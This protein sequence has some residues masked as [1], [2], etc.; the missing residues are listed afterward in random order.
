MVRSK[1]ALVDLYAKHPRW[2][3]VLAGAALLLVLSLLYLVPSYVSA[4]R[5]LYILPIWLATRMGGRISGLALV[6]LCTLTGGIAEWR[7]DHGPQEVL[8]INLLLRFG[9]LLV[10]MLL[11]AQVEFALQ[12]HQRMALTDPLTGLLNRHALAEYAKR[13]FDRAFLRNESMT[14]VVIDCDG[15]KLLN[16]NYGHQAGD[17]VLNVLARSLEGQTR[18]SDLIARIGGDEF[19]VVLQNTGL[20]EAKQIMNRVDISFTRAVRDLGYEAGLSIGYGESGADD[21]DLESVIDRADK[22]MYEHKQ[23]KRAAVFLN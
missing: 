16:D 17:H 3:A 20:D 21:S 6:V 14:V 22:S 19:A 5:V 9:S 10:V 7:L 11:I 1:Q 2:A 4:V 12:K 13:V 15:F 8:A 18:K 23:F